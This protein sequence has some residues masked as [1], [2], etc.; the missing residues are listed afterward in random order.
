MAVFA[1]KPSTLKGLHRLGN[2]ESNRGL[3]I[4][5]EWAKLGVKVELDEANDTLRVHCQTPIGTHRPAWR[6]PHG[7]GRGDSRGGRRPV[8]IMN[9]EC[10]AKSYPASS[11][12]SNR[13]GFRF[14][15]WPSEAWDP[16]HQHR[17][18]RPRQPAKHRTDRPRQHGHGHPRPKGQPHAQGR[19]Q[20]QALAQPSAAQR[21]TLPDVIQHRRAVHPHPKDPC[22]R[23][24]HGGDT[25]TINVANQQS[26]NTPPRTR[27]ATRLNAARAKRLST[28][29]AKKTAIPFL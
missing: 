18:N 5:E 4:Q 7:H 17:G 8:E 25:G 13:S 6:P 14:R 23:H 3:A 21:F 2:K 20:A 29:D 15:W 12:T 1:K 16:G 28:P 10:V 26:S 9:A 24:P 22:D 27:R 11:T 19:F